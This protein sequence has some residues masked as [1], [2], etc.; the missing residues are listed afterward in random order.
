MGGRAEL[1]SHEVVETKSHNVA[2]A[3][4]EFGISSLNLPCSVVMG[5]HTPTYLDQAALA[6]NVT[7][8]LLPNSVLA[9]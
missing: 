5:I 3:G 4:L 6:E 8:N 2:Q 9:D 1:S 7:T